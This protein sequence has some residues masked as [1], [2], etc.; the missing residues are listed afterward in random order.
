MDTK[1]KLPCR[2]KNY[3]KV[4][5]ELKLFIIDQIHNGRISV[6]YA[7]KKHDISRATIQYWIKKYS[8]FEQK[9]LGMSKQD[10][11]KK[12][13]EK[14]EELEFVKDFQQ[15]IIA[16]MEIITGV[17]MSKKSLPKTLAEEIQKKKQ[18]RLKE[19]G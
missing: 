8:T 1:T 17:D 16:D 6:N 15:D 19:N 11:I 12:L 5:F 13:K 2:K 7:A 3:N 18:N 10:E 4:G 9:K 14:I